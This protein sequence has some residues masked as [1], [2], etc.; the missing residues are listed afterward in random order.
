MN[1]D[2]RLRVELHEDGVAHQ[3]TERLAARDMA[4]SLTDSFADRVIVSHDGPEV[5]CYAGTRE[6]AEAAREVISRLAAE[7]DWQITFT[8][9]RWHPTA[10]RWEDPDAPLP[11]SGEQAAA[12]HAE[13]VAQERGESAEQGYPEYEVR[14]KCPSRADASALAERLRSE[15]HP[16]V[17]RGE[18]VVL[19]ATDEDSARRL[20]DQVRAEAPPG[21][22]VVAEASVAEVAQE[23]PYGTTFS[24]FAFFGGL[25]G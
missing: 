21:T 23:T 22:E 10:E 17:H 4:H 15:G 16:V 25:A 11:T 18:F 12:K 9:Q 8:L 20:A 5:N 24:P 6:Q 3:L 14:V 2:W 1:D 7:H 13:L 19:G